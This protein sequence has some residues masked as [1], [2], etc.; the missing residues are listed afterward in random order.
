[1]C[2]AMGIHMRIPMVVST[3]IPLS[4]MGSYLCFSNFP[5]V[6]HISHM[7]CPSSEAFLGAASRAALVN[8]QKPHIVR[9]IN[10]TPICTIGP[11]LVSYAHVRPT[12]FRHTVC[13]YGDI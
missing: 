2:V 11:Y 7:C 6:N 1:M 3:G 12:P 10:I 5:P 13:I 8:A 9:V 4:M